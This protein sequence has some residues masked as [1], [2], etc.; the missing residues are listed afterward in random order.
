M[1]KAERKADIETKLPQLETNMENALLAAEAVYGARENWYSLLEDFTPESQKQWLEKYV[2]PFLDN[3]SLVM[4]TEGKPQINFSDGSYLSFSV[5]N[6]IRDWVYSP[7]DGV[8][9]TFV[10]VSDNNGI[11]NPINSSFH[12]YTWSYEN[13]TKDELRE[14]C[15]SGVSNLCTAYIKANGWV[16]PD[17]YPLEY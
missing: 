5:N 12:A 3:A 9:T 2:M 10:A 4:N 13:A 1:T 7:I 8:D 17:D 11:G 16:I 14:K 6:Q 15:L